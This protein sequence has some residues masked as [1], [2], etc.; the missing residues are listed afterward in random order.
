MRTRGYLLVLAV[1]LAFFAAAGPAAAGEPGSRDDAESS[2]SARSG[3]EKINTVSAAG[4]TTG[5]DVSVSQD[6]GKSQPCFKE[7]AVTTTPMPIMIRKVSVLIEST[8]TNSD[9]E[10]NGVYVG[11]TPLQVSL[12]EG[13]HHLKVSKEGFLPWVK[14]VKAFNGLYVSA[15]LVKSSTIKGDVTKSATAQ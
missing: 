13:V 2:G 12:K 6:M 14:T 11:S 5:G 9:I 3:M 4:P 7:G 15:T 8:P 1:A 10:L